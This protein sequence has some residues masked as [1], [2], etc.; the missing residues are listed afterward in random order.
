MAQNSKD[1]ITWQAT[2]NSGQPATVRGLHRSPDDEIRA[3]L[4]TQLMCTRKLDTRRFAQRHGVDFDRYFAQGLTR[5]DA[6]DPGQQL[7]DRQSANWT[8]SPDG[9]LLLRSIAACFDA[10]R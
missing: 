10:Y 9:T 2:I 6:L 7:V 3:D 5:L 8:V 1:L 4:I